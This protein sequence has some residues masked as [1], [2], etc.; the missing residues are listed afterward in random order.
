MHLSGLESWGLSW[1]PLLRPFFC[2]FMKSHPSKKDFH[3]LFDMADMESPSLEIFK[4][5]QEKVLSNLT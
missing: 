3:H 1:S 5:R 4:T 2:D